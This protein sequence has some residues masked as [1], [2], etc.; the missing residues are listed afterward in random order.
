MAPRTF[1]YAAPPD[2]D[3]EYAAPLE[4]IVDYS[5]RAALLTA[6]DQLADATAEFAGASAV[7]AEALA[8]D[9]DARLNLD[10]LEDDFRAR[11]YRDGLPGTNEAQRAAY[12]A[13]R[14]ADDP[15]VGEARQCRDRAHRARLQA[16]HDFRVADMA[17][18]SLRVRLE[19]LTALVR[20]GGA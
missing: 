18:K 10:Y 5:L 6:C 20:G 16:E 4:S 17:Q 14:L 8:A 3:A 7:L 11:A 19:A 12:L 13:V 1:T 2:A 9:A 15:T